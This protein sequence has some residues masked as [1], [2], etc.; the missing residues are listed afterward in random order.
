MLASGKLLELFNSCA[1][2]KNYSGSKAVMTALEIFKSKSIGLSGIVGF[3]DF[4]LN[5]KKYYCPFVKDTSSLEN[6]IEASRDLTELPRRLED[7]T[8]IS[9]E[10]IIPKDL[11]DGMKNASTYHSS[12][13]ILDEM[14]NAN[15]L[16][17]HQKISQSDKSEIERLLSASMDEYMTGMYKWQLGYDDA[18][19]QAIASSLEKFKKQV[20][21]ALDLEK[22]SLKLWIAYLE[23][24]SKRD[25]QLSDKDKII[26]KN[27]SLKET[28]KLVKNISTRD[29]EILRPVL[30]RYVET[31]SEYLKNFLEFCANG[32]TQ[33]VIDAINIGIDVNVKDTDGDTALMR[34]VDYGHTEI[35]NALL[36]AGAEVNAERTGT[37][38]SVLS[39]NTALV[40]AVT[41]GNVEIVK[42]LLNAGA[43][44]NTEDV[45]HIPVL[46]IATREKDNIGIVKALL[47]AGANVNASDRFGVTAMMHAA[48]DGDMEIVKALLNA[49]A[50]ANAGKTALLWAAK[51]GHGRIVNILLK[52]GAKYD[53]YKDGD[54]IDKC[55]TKTVKTLIEA[56]MAGDTI[57]VNSLIDEGVDVNAK[58]DSK[59]ALMYAVKSGRTEI[60]KTLIKAGADVNAKE[61]ILFGS[62]TALM[63]AAETGNPETVNALLNAGANVSKKVLNY[64]RKNKSLQGTDALKRL[65]QLVK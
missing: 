13:K 25:N 46:M 38:N 10:Y 54:V 9:N 18:S 12:F 60:V 63:L 6:I 47:D 28:D 41:H 22:V 11:L 49:G 5:P 52:A 29:I 35:V 26:L 53:R 32:S 55:R 4:Y 21:S 64:A 65:E 24:L 62:T 45:D 2:A 37:W 44:P 23:F 48:Y 30:Q 36:Q 34:A 19:A 42:A 57:T 16:I 17:S 15:N 61:G 14:K 33:K 40:T 58:Y 1:K 50:N 39:G 7:F 27:V 31:K 20:G 8:A 51:N 3:L 59:T 43:D 56:I